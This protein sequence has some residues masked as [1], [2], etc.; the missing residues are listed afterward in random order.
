MSVGVMKDYKLKQR[1]LPASHTLGPSFYHT[2]FLPFFLK[3]KVLSEKLKIVSP[4]SY[5]CMSPGFS[6]WY[7]KARNAKKEIYCSTQCMGGA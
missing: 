6:F 1:N 3:E 7:K 2:F 5:S 4:S